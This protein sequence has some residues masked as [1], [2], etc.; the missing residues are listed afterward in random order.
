MMSSRFFVEKSVTLQRKMQ[1]TTSKAG[2]APSNRGNQIK[3][4]DKSKWQ[5]ESFY[6]S[7]H[8]SS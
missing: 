7:P 6:H 3:K 5:K 4:Q 2:T 1:N 8:Y